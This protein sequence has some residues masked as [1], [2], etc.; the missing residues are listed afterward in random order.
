[1][2]DLFTEQAPEA[3]F[4]D[5]V[6][7]GKKFKDPDALA[8]KVVHA[9]K[10]IDN[11]EQELAEMRTEL[12]ARL[13]VEEM[14]DKFKPAPAEPTREVPAH[15]PQEPGSKEIDLTAEVQ[16]LLRAE[17]DKD[18]RDH[19]IEATRDGLKERFGP[20]YNQRLLEIAG[21]L[22]VS[23]DFLTQ[24]AAS[25]P[26][27]FF[28]L[29]DSV[30]ERDNTRPLHAPQPNRDPLKT[31]STQ[32]RKNSAYFQELRREKPDLYFSRRVQNEMHQEAVKQGAS[33][34]S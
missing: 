2:S 6:G 24:M 21:D 32:N 8:K 10:H 3:T 15:N 17:K 33:F 30:A 12:S 9:D 14:L 4:E 31:Q 23:K 26:T 7:E 28:K 34:Y 29:I 19:N 16:R 25:T 1:M 22:S 27:G 5:L 18:K 13:K 11:L 20:D